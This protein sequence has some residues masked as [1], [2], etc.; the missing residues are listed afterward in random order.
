MQKIYNELKK[1]N[2]KLAE[3]SK[4]LV[5]NGIYS[6][7][8]VANASLRHRVNYNPKVQEIYDQWKHG[9]LKTKDVQ[10]HN[11]KI[12]N[13]FKEIKR[14]TIK[15]ELIAIRDVLENALMELT[16]AIKRD[17]KQRLL[18]VKSMLQ[19][20]LYGGSND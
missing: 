9:R 19:S 12:A 10:K 11:Q 3:F 6:T 8:K 7:E 5:E 1:H 13:V 15:D 14:R 20:G 2:G 18:E 16:I 17:D 4:V